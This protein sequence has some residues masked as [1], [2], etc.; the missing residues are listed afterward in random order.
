MLV[1]TSELITKWQ[2]KY[3]AW[4]KYVMRMFR[5]R[6]DELINSFEQIAFDHINI[7]VM[8]YLKKKSIAEANKIINISHQNPA[9]E[10]GTTRVV[11]SRVLKQFEREKKIKLSRGA[12]ALL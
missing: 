8:K 4:N 10:L 12:I 3:P 1:F 11:L 9:H 6:Y 7:R 5:S 2:L